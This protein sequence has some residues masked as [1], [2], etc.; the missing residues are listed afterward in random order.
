MAS[1]RREI[2]IKADP[3]D[4][5]DALRDVGAVHQRL[6]PGFVTDARMEE[7]ARIVTFGNGVIARELIIDIDD[8][9]RRLVWSAAGGRLTHH[10]ASAQIFPDSGRS[11]RFVWIADL[12]PH[13]M[14]PAIAQMI[15]QG[16]SV[17]KRTLEREKG[18][19]GES[20]YDDEAAIRGV[21]DRWREATQR[22]DIETVLSLMTDDVVFLTPGNPPMNKESFATGF[23]AF[24]GK[25]KFDAK[26]DVKEIRI[27]GS[28]AY[29]ESFMSLTMDGKTRAGNILS[30]F[31]KVDG[32]WLLARD[33]NF[34]TLTP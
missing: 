17:I 15:D 29:A 9:A 8:A 19:H 11:T 21:M 30:I 18:L 13:E 16:L 5:W 32:K 12:L 14:A 22:G 20:M 28:L 31:R 24:A 33:A 3:N 4:V 10:N 23:R 6:A 7:G 25:V 1:I 2:A 27:D 34:V 26:Q